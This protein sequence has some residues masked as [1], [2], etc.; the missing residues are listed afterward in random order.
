MRHLLH[1][2][3]FLLVL[4][5]AA[6]TAQ[7]KFQPISQEAYQVM[8]QFCE[9]DRGIPLNTHIVE[10]VDMEYCTREKI[11]FSSVNNERVP[12]YLAIP[13][14]G[15]RPYP[16]VLMQHG[17]G[18]EKESWWNGETYCNGSILTKDLLESGYAVL[19]LDAQYFGE[20]MGRND[21]EHPRVFTVEK[22]WYY[23]LNSS[24][25]QTVK[26]YRRAMDYLATR[27]E[28][29]TSRIG[30]TGYSMGGIQTFILTAIDS[31]IKTSVSVVPLPQGMHGASSDYY[32]A[33]PK[34]HASRIGNRP[35]LLL[36][37]NEDKSY[38]P[39]QGQELYELLNSSQKEIIWYDSGHSLPGEWTRE[40]LNWYKKYLSY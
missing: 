4:F 29:D 2:L 8:T 22:Q 38:T 36:M 6:A 30:L 24:V 39:E 13:K 12:G 17:F 3:Y 7:E 34:H 9:Y 25:V 27:L 31:R 26:D 18:H 14:M 11:V 5:S 1:N 40:A 23:R 15:N 19:M 35:F 10:T 37:G 16:I 21:F 28:I 33:V 20:R 32:L